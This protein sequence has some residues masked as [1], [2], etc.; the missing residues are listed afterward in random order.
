MGIQKRLL[1]LSKTIILS[2]LLC[3]AI[4]FENAQ[5][6]RIYLLITIFL[7]YMAIGYIRGLAIHKSKVYF[8]SFI[9]DIALVFLLEHNS[10][11]LINYFF[12]SFYIIILLESALSL[13]FRRGMAVGTATVLVSSIKYIYLIYYKF[14]LASISQSV[15][16]LMAN[17]LILVITGLAQLNKEEKERKEL[18]YKELL[19][20]HKELKQYIDE[21][22]RLSVVEERNRI[23]RDL[24]DTLGHNMTA[25]IMQLQ[26]AG[27]FLKEDI[28]KTEKMLEDAIKNAKD[29]MAGIREVVETLREEEIDPDDAGPFKRL[30]DEFGSRTGAEIILDIEGEKTARDQGADAAVYHIVQEA[31]TNAIR[32][33]KASKI[34]VSLGYSQDSVT[35][36]VKDNGKGEGHIEEGYGLKG[37]RERVKAFS[38]KVEMGADEG[39]YIRGILYLGREKT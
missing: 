33:G 12:H 27:Y 32:H 15:F 26:M 17:V 28:P 1:Y 25:L 16:F 7:V 9:F 8:L 20:A 38:G 18:L 3:A 11:L 14:D 6:Q 34:Y 36:Q 29:S 23:A 30:I 13:G 37:I 10:R 35:F 2:I 24:H 22:N 31:M 21:L 19:D 4:Y 39:F 5:R